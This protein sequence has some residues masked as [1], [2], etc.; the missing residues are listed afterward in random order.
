MID[1]RILCQASEKG[2]IVVNECL[3][4]GYD[5]DTLKLEKLLILMHGIMLSAY[6]DPFF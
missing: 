6:G 4:R 3:D 5:I 2:K 1:R